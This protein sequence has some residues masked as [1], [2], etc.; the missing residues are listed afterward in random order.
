VSQSEFSRSPIFLKIDPLLDPLAAYFLLAGPVKVFVY[1]LIS[2]VTP[3]ALVRP[4]IG[5]VYYGLDG[6]ACVTAVV[7]TIAALILLSSRRVL[8]LRKDRRYTARR[9]S[10]LF[11]DA[12]PQ[13]ICVA[14]F[15]ALTLMERVVL[16]TVY[17]SVISLP[18]IVG[19]IA[20]IAGRVRLAWSALVA[21]LA[22]TASMSKLVVMILPLM[23]SGVGAALAAVLVFL[24]YPTFN[25]LRWWLLSIEQG[26]G[27]GEFWQG[28]ALDR[29]TITDSLVKMLHRVQSFEGMYLVD[30]YTDAMRWTSS[31]D[32]AGFAQYLSYD[33]LGLD[34]GLAVSLQSQ[35]YCSFDNA[36]LASAATAILT[37]VTAKWIRLVCRFSRQVEFISSI[38]IFSILTDGFLPNRLRYFACGIACFHCMRYFVRRSTVTKSKSLITMPLETRELCAARIRR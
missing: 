32:Y 27:V 33:V 13:A 7:Y 34:Y 23:V 31:S 38:I 6:I 16:G 4:V 8:S 11:V 19:G 9:D 29:I 15:C 14:G 21:I 1:G 17:L 18:I 22:V 12:K 3:E 2:T 37:V 30:D 28:T 10:E 5:R 35:L 26:N 25:L 24:M 20:A 36:I